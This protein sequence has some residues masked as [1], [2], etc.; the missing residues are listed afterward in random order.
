MKLIF[1]NLTLGDGQ[2]YTLGRKV[3]GLSGN[4]DLTKIKIPRSDY[5]R[6]ISSYLGDKIR[7]FSGWILGEGLDDIRERKRE[8]KNRL[9]QDYT[10]TLVD[11]YI[12]ANGDTVV[13][14]SYTFN[15]RLQEA[16][17]DDEQWFADKVP[18]SIMISSE[19]PYLYDVNAISDTASIKERGFTFPLIFPFVFT[20]QD[21]V[22][23]VNNTGGVPV[24]P[25]ITLHGALRNLEIVHENA[26]TVN[27]S[28]TYSGVLTGS[29]ELII[30]PFPYD[31][32]KVR[33]N[34]V[35][36]LRNT[37]YNFAALEMPVGINTFTFFLDSDEDSNTEA[38]ISFSPAYIGI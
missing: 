7:I 3:L 25:T 1:D 34:G 28:F 11:D 32:I 16:L 17:C 36:A 33:K 10:F 13:F 12:D 5:S 14:A 2:N 38:S 9:R 21:N 24:F 19:D 20:G 37:N 6:H 29:D 27:K 8:L 23:V 22:I 26:T 18:Y 30:T 4:L 35:S 31:P 15:G